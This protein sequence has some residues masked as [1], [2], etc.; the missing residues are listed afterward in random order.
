MT[1]LLIF[2]NSF[3]NSAG[4]ISNYALIYQF[5]WQS[6]WLFDRHFYFPFQSGWYMKSY[7]LSEDL[8]T[9]TEEILNGKF[10]FLCSDLDKTNL[11]NVVTV[12]NE[13][14]SMARDIILPLVQVFHYSLKCSLE[15]VEEQFLMVITS[16]VVFLFFL[17]IITIQRTVREKRGPSLFIG[18]TQPTH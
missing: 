17:Q 5:N 12:T 6:R 3:S 14:Q 11:G 9:F 18:F 1:L 10:H 8:A 16:N 13:S 15:I 2:F 4:W 7:L